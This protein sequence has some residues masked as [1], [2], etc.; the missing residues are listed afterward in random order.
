VN[1]RGSLFLLIP[2]LLAGCKKEY[3]FEPP[4]E[5]ERVAE[6]AAELTPAT[7]DT[8][9]WE[10]EASRLQEGNEIYAARC[11]RCHGT[12]GEGGTEYAEQRDLDVPSLV[13]PDWRWADSLGAVRRR[14]FTG[15]PGGMPTWG[16]AGISPREIDATAYY[17]LNVLRPDVLDAAAG[18]G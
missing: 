4:E 16:I 13:E 1:L 12:L 18:G 7:F 11:R 3:R 5:E 6:A 15:H 10:D 14:V 8:V 2:V 9:R 17:I